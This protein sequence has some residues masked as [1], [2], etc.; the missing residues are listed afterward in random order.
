MFRLAATPPGT[1]LQGLSNC[2]LR[3]P[4]IW[5]IKS[6]EIY[7]RAGKLCFQK[8]ITQDYFTFIFQ[9]TEEENPDQQQSIRH[10]VF[11]ECIGF[12]TSLS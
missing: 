3:G 9:G 10:M 11:F 6:L 4:K 7:I 8:A 1:G 5:V 12:R 2:C